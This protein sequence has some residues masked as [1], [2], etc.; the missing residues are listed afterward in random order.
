M[1]TR[2]TGSTMPST[3]ERAAC[4]RARAVARRGGVLKKLLLVLAIL[5]VAVPVALVLAID[6]IAK[7]GIAAAGRHALG[8]PTK[9][10]DVSIGVFSGKTAVRGLEVD[11]PS[12]YTAAQ[13]VKLG[14]IAVDAGVGDF[15]GEKIEIQRVAISDLV[16]EVEK[17]AEGVLNVKRIS[18]NIGK[19]TGGSGEPAEPAGEPKEAV[20][21]ELRLERV[22]VN[23]RNLVGGKDGVVEVKLPDLVIR[24]LS[25]K[26]GVDVLA[27][28]LSGVVIGSVMKGVIAANIQ[29]LGADVVGGLQGAVEGIGAA[30]GGPLR[31]AVDQ[32]LQGAGEALKKVGAELGDVGKKA[33]EGA[34]KAVE[35]AVEGAGEKLK[36]GVGGALEGIFG[37]KK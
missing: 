14:E 4:A 22:Q 36:E 33:L 8:T 35:G 32:G 10:S 28:E 9:A 31:D 19:A 1:T 25:S 2:T 21:H 15:L 20:I 23:L 3:P 18:E 24:E 34:G 17:D 37:G 6:P 16:V 11:N 30:I 29:G 13:F 26:G 5:V 12:G 27:S 7:A